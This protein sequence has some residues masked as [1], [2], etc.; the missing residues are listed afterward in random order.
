MFLPSSTEARHC[1]GH[2]DTRNMHTPTHRLRQH[3]W[4]RSAA[5]S[6]GEQCVALVGG[7]RAS[8][9]GKVCR[10]RSPSLQ[11]PLVASTPILSVRDWLYY[12]I[13]LRSLYVALITSLVGQW[14]EKW[15]FMTTLHRWATL[16][17]KSEQVVFL[18]HDEWGMWG[19]EPIQTTQEP[20]NS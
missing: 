20:L 6:Q 9:N 19:L 13:L 5:S 8:Y 2:K 7:E 14:A 4:S 3:D 10:W 16:N 11:L 12:M 18:H 1:R 15:K 17:T